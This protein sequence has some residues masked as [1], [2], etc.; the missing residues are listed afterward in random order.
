MTRQLKV[1]ATSGYDCKERPAIILRG[2]W[3][4]ALQFNIGDKIE[5]S[6]KREEIIIK[7]RA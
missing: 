5:V 7:K 3:L 1:Y 4:K 2:D 6:C